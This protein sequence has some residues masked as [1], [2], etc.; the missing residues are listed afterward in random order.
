[1]C[2]N[3]CSQ[4]AVVLTGPEQ[5]AV[6]LPVVPDKLRLGRSVTADRTRSNWCRGSPRGCQ[7]LSQ[8]QQ[9]LPGH[10]PLFVSRRQRFTTP[11]GQAV[12]LNPW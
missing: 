4:K 5:G 9:H 3:I 1:M 11:T 12:H 2:F 7:G 10:P 6:T 8:G